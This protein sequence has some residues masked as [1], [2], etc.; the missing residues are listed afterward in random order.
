M[1]TENNRKALGQR[2]TTT[3]VSLAGF[4]F[5][6]ALVSWFASQRIGLL[7]TLMMGVIVCL[8][9][10]GAFFIKATWTKIDE[11]RH[12]SHWSILDSRLLN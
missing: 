5:I 7:A 9:I 12:K 2:I 1:T 8:G 4:V 10:G 6:G 3:A 11:N